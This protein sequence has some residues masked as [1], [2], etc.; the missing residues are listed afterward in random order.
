MRRLTPR[1]LPTFSMSCTAHTWTAKDET[2]SPPRSNSV[3]PS[4]NGRGQAPRVQLG[5]ARDDGGRDVSGVAL[6]TS[7]SPVASGPELA[8][9]LKDDS[10]SIEQPSIRGRTSNSFRPAA[11]PAAGSPPLRSADRS[12]HGLRGARCTAGRVGGLPRRRPDWRH[13]ARDPRAGLERV[14]QAGVV[15]LEHE[16]GGR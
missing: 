16:A 12:M 1:S 2:S 9:L 8:D 13:L 10:R 7:A 4:P 3:Q 5:Q 11:R 6:M 15:R 14:I